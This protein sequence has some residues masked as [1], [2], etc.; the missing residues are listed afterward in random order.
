[1][2]RLALWLLAAIASL[3][4]SACAAYAQNAQPVAMQ[5][6]IVDGAW[7]EATLQGVY[8]PGEAP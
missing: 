8:V 2:N 6:A 5:G 7:L 4:L 3:V 1:M